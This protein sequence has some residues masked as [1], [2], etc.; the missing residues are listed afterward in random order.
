MIAKP[1]EMNYHETYSTII[2]SWRPQKPLVEAEAFLKDHLS[3]SCSLCLLRGEAECRGDARLSAC[4]KHTLD[5][6]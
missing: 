1:P 3:W 5:Q 2:A 4:T 6:C